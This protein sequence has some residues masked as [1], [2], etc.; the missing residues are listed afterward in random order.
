MFVL[1]GTSPT[2]RLEVRRAALYVQLVPKNKRKLTQ[3]QLKSIIAAKISDIPDARAWYV[4]E[5]GERELSFSMLSR[6]G[7]DLNAAIGKVEGALRGVPGLPQ[8][9]RVGLDGSARDS[10]RATPRCGSPPR[11]SAR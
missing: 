4:N 1:G 6:S 8:C 2:G 5:R 11:R 10:H 3:K 7:D 9:C